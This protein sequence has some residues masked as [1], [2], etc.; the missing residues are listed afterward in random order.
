M[1]QRARERTFL[2]LSGI[3]VLAAL[4]IGFLR[5]G[6]PSRQREFEAD[7]KRVQNLHQITQWI[8]TQNS[9]G[10]PLPASL[11]ELQQGASFLPIRDPVTSAPY[12][13]RLKGGKEYELCAVF[14]TASRDSI[15]QPQPGTE[16][17]F[18]SHPRGRHCFQLNAA[19]RAPM[20]QGW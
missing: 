17:H 1:R 19:R 3:A 12:E 16:S 5:L 9:A 10:A 14:D 18:W 2:L 20:Y 13:Y 11:S 8:Q 4:I 6:P 15:D 7:T